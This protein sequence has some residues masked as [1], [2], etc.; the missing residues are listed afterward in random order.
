MDNRQWK[1]LES[2]YL[3]KRPWLTVRRDKVLLPTGAINPEFYILEYPMWVNVIAL[4]REGQF[5]LVRQYRHGLGETHYELCAGVVEQ[6]EEP[7]A[8]AKRELLEETG[9]GGGKWHLLMSISPNASTVNNLSYCFVAT[10][11][12][13]LSTEQHLDA[14]E[15]LTVHLF[16]EVE[17]RQMLANN[18][19]RQALMAAPLWR[20]FCE[21]KC[22]QNRSRK[23]EL[24]Q[25]SEF[26]I[27]NFKFNN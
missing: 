19:I 27:S 14:T 15:D 22:G 12:E 16:D 1:V 26:Q 11:V 18:E 25:I 17:V 3:F 20:Y 23:I 6:G 2:E 24:N 7:L 8:A 4:T 9:F 5:V 21:K 10:D 13:R